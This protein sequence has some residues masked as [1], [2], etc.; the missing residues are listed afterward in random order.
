MSAGSWRLRALRPDDR[1]AVLEA[2]VDPEIRRWRHCP[3]P[4]SG[5]VA[6]YIADRAAGWADETRCTWAVCDP[7]T[8]EMLGEVGLEHLDL[9]M[10]TAEVTCWALDR[11]RGR[12]MTR[13]AVAAVVQFGFDGLGLARIGYGWAEPNVA[14]A[15][16]AQALGFVPEGRLRSAWMA[17]GERSDILISGLL[18]DDPA[19]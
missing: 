17:D 15:R 2:A 11:A 14:S 6:A 1:V 9:P 16:I 19:A 7:G 5:A 10:G 3:D 13:A 12:G 18:A 4:T 8:D